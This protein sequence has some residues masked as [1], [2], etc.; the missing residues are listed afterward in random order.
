M[1]F[2]TEVLCEE[3]KRRL[4]A[5]QLTKKPR[6]PELDYIRWLVIGM[7][8]ANKNFAAKLFG[9]IFP[10]QAFGADSDE[11]TAIECIEM[12]RHDPKDNRARELFAETLGLDLRAG[13]ALST[14][15]LRVLQDEQRDAWANRNDRAY[16]LFLEAR[17]ALSKLRTIARGR[18]PPRKVVGEKASGKQC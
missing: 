10:A 9:E 11:R 6:V 1:T 17:N 13:E 16:Q 2:D 15:L 4:L 14:A 5:E 3:I 12:M 7:A 8:L 18:R